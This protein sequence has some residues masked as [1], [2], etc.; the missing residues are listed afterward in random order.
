MMTVSVKYNDLMICKALQI[1]MESFNHSFEKI[2]VLNEISYVSKDIDWDDFYMNIVYFSIEVT[3]QYGN[4]EVLYD[5]H[6]RI[7][8]AAATEDCITARGIPIMRYDGNNY[9]QYVID[10]LSAWS[11][12]QEIDFL[13]LD[14]D[15]KD[16]Y[17]SSCRI[18]NSGTDK[19]NNTFYEV[20][21]DLAK[22]DID[23]FN[24]MGDVLLGSKGY[25]GHD[26]YTFEDRLGTIIN[27]VEADTVIRLK[28][29]QNLKLSVNS[30]EWEY[31]DKAFRREYKNLAF[32][33]A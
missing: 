30:R 19:L 1:K 24:L 11:K 9:N 27:K 25:L 21:L 6:F 32:V 26:S 4:E 28:N 3:D 29:Y 31:I 23:L 18:W 8:D 5:F 15:K 7:E 12:N 2:F 13:S 17:C 10:I 22:S 20:D 16:A 33:M 14:Q